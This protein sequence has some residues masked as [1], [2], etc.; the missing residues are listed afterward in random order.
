MA[1]GA[2][3]FSHP[4][5]NLTARVGRMSWIGCTSQRL[6]PILPSQADGMLLKEWSMS[7]SVCVI[8]QT[9]EGIR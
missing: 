4:L 6:P 7:V 2:R 3:D 1:C 9:A 5:G 8:V